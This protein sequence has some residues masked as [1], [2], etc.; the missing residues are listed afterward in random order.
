MTSITSTA[1]VPQH[2]RPHDGRVALVTGAARG[3]GEAI[4]RQLH[5]DG[6]AVVLADIL[7]D[8]V[9]AVAS[10]LDV[11][12]RRAV[13][14]PID[15][16]VEAEVDG[17]IEAVFERFGRLDILVQCAAVQVEKRLHETTTEEWD[18][19]HATN[20]RALFCG[21]RA[22]LPRM[23][24]RGGG[25][26]LNVGST[27]GLRVD[28]ILAAYGVMKHGVVGLTRAIAADPTYARAGI[29]ALTLCP[30]DVMTDMQ[31]TFWAALPDPEGARAHV[32][33]QYP[34]GRIALPAE[35][36]RLASLLVSDDAGIVSGAEIVADNGR[37][38]LYY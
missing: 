28:P 15:L 36:A 27:L 11:P 18:R 4:A 19:L 22:V 20:L 3:L 8:E 21:A 29:R 37:F 38:P 1:T 23:M 16:T 30:G 2:H 10:D 35:V 26:I 34:N 12:D 25:V 33:A 31:R 9:E 17:L 13:A 7:A 24:E 14:H 6:A 5:A 32:E